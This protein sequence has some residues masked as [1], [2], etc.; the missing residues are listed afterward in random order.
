MDDVGREL[1]EL[2]LEL[3]LDED[4]ISCGKPVGSKTP[5][6]TVVICTEIDVD[7]PDEPLNVKVDVEELRMV[8]EGATGFPTG[9]SKT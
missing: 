8:D 3:E 7:E 5:L 1:L 6:K 2:E 4:R 9:I